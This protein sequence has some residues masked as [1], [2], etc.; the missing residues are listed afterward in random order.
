ML[1]GIKEC[2]FAKACNP[3]DSKFK[4]FNPPKSIS[5]LGQTGWD[6]ARAEADCGG[7]GLMS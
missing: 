3:Q 7:G 4:K 6:G 2:P 5:I 1:S